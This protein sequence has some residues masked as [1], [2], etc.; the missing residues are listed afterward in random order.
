MNACALAA[1]ALL[2]S[3]FLRYGGFGLALLTLPVI[4]LV[5]YAAMALVPVIAVVKVMKV[6]ENSTNYSINNTARQVL[7]LPT[8][9]EMNIL[10][11][12]IW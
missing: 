2:A 7:W 5:S 6:A 9:A 4:S 10:V 1:Q 8:T 3:R 11:P 12:F